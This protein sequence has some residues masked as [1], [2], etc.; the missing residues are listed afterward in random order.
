VGAGSPLDAVPELATVDLTGPVPYRPNTLPPMPS[1]LVVDDN[2]GTRNALRLLLG[3]SGCDPAWVASGA[4]ALELLQ[5][6]TFD[7]VVLDWMMP[8][9]D[10]LEVLRRLRGDPATAHVRVI[11]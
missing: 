9:M 8:G 11:V 3:R 4:D 7:A 2:E 6:L 10:G 5:H 1:V